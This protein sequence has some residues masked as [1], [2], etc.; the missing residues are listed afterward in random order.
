MINT[1]MR[2]DN[3]LADLTSGDFGSIAFRSDLETVAHDLMLRNRK[4]EACNL[5][6][7]FGRLLECGKKKQGKVIESLRIFLNDARQ[8]FL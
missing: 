3:I 8:I 4:Y 7:T 6:V 5:L 1:L 2:I